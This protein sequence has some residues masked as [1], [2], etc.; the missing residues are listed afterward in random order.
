MSI[1]KNDKTPYWQYDFQIEGRRFHG[2][3]GT[4]SKEDAKNIEAAAR[5]KAVTQIHFPEQADMKLRDAFGRYWLEHA[6]HK[7]SADDIFQKMEC[8]IDG[9]GPDKTLRTITNMDITDYIAK[10]RG[11]MKKVKVDDKEKLV[12]VR[13]DSSVNREITLLRAMLNRAA[14]AW[15]IAVKMPNWKAHHLREP[16]GRVR[17]LSADEEKNLFA[18]LRKDFHP[19]VRFCLITGARVTSVRKLTWK[20]ID[21]ATGEIRLEVKSKFMGDFHTLP[22][23]PEIGAVL[24]AVKGQ[25][26]IFVFTYLSEGK[27]A[28]KREKG[29][30]YPF[31]RDGWRRTWAKALRDAGI[32]DFRFHDLR[33]TAATQ[34]LRATKNLAAVKEVL[35]HRDVTTTMRYAHV[36][37]DDIRAALS[38]N[39]PGI[40]IA[41]EEKPPLKIVVSNG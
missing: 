1:Y 6:Q 20:S 37:K 3:T 8:L 17:S 13:S 22:I 2:S 29:K 27:V 31:A 28:R 41:T 5:R 32:S 14:S 39:S 4:T 38:R 24:D 21:R 16:R 26:P 19:L 11:E 10:R 25:H 9:I 15:D 18:N 7:K 12:R 33:H 23:T 34:M 35:G 30:R 40:E 36:M